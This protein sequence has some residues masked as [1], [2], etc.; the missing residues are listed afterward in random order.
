MELDI[1]IP[2]RNL[3]IEYCGLYWH[4][5]VYREDT[6]HLDKWRACRDENIDLIQVF[7]D[8]W[9]N[10]RSAVENLI[11]L[12][13]ARQT[14]PI[15]VAVCNSYVCN[16][17]EVDD[18]AKEFIDR[19]SLCGLRNDSTYYFLKSVRGIHCALRFTLTSNDD[20]LLEEFLYDST[21]H[22]EGGHAA[23][24][25]EF[26]RR[27]NPNQI[28]GCADLRWDYGQ[29]YADLG[30]ECSGEPSVKEWFFASNSLLRQEP[31]ETLLSEACECEALNKIC[32]AGHVRWVWIKPE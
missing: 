12:R 29:G 24:F 1:H 22:V 5:D 6:Y 18:L 15:E 10:H 16:G 9:I 23:L 14:A 19:T 11:R 17:S 2:S 28:D 27:N 31:S 32:D 21:K 26:A 8:E 4:S 7:E 3:A 20:R 25:A 30:F 13:L